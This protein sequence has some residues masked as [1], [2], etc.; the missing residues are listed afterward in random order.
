MTNNNR[1]EATALAVE[2]KN[3]KFKKITISRHPLG[4]QDIL[5]DIYYCGICHS[6]IHEARSEWQQGIY[7]M[8]PGHEIAGKVVAVG[9]DVEKFK[10]GDLAG[11]GCMVNSCCTCPSCTDN[12]EQYC[13]KGM[14]PTYNSKDYVRSEPNT[15]GGYSSNIVVNERFAVNVPENAPLDKVGPLLCSGIT[16]YSPIKFSNVKKGDKVAVAGFGGLGLMAA[17]YCLALGAEVYVFA[18]NKRKEEFAKK[19]GITKLY[20]S[21]ENVEERFDFI[22]ST[23]PTPYNPTSY[24]KLLKRGGEMAIVGLPPTEVIPMISI[25]NLVFMGGKKVYGSLIG[26]MKETQEMLDFSLK[27]NIYPETVIVKADQVDWVYEQLTTGKGQFRYVI[28][29]KTL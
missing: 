26:G 17:K 12:Q 2:N 10:V 28:D 16:T 19:L 27:N 25:A 11:V 20:D 22:I 8:V 7:P 14:V 15:Y 24:L 5:I 18:R 3:A 9:K 6:D 13:E 23:I 21:T 4:D 1:I 29:M